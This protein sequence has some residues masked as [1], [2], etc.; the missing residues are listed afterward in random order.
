MYDGRPPS[1]DVGN[2]LGRGARDLGGYRE[3]E[4][5]ELSWIQKREE[6]S[7]RKIG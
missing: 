3:G 4:N 2:G 1:G 5:G 7:G 6:M